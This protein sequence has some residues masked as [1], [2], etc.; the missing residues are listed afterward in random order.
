MAWHH[1][2]ASGNQSKFRF[3]AGKYE[4]QVLARVHGCKSPLILWTYTLVVPDE[5]ALS[6][7]DGRDQVWFD[8]VPDSGEF[9]PR[10]ESQVVA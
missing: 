10:L 1:F 4:L 2:V 5:A 7:H 6:H 8:L 9:V 3:T